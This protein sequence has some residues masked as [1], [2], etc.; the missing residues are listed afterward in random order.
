MNLFYIVIFL[1]FLL[2]IFIE[3]NELGKYFLDLEPKSG[4]NLKKIIN[5]LQKCVDYDKDFIKWRMILFQV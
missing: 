2:I 5:K 4:D 1:I 3:Y